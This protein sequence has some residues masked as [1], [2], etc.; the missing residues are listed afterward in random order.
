[1]RI[2]LTL[3]KNKETVPYEHQMRLVGR[4]HKWLGKNEEHDKLSLYSMSWLEGG[5]ASAKG[6][7]FPQGAKWFISAYNKDIIKQVALSIMEDAEV[8]YGMKVETMQIEEAPNYG[9]KHT[10]HVANPVLV[11]RNTDFNIK[12]YTY[13]DHEA[14]QYLSETLQSKL[15]TAGLPSEGLSV[16]FDTSYKDPK[17]KLIQIKGT[18]NRC[19]RCPIIIEGSPEQIAFAWQVGIGNSTGVGF[20]ALR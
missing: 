8:C 1:M 17:I 13:Q 18:Q 2:H 4:L 5:K 10:F 3:S 9:Q 14:N 16:K 20:G 12:H 19:S 15:K 7:D 6:L 11:K